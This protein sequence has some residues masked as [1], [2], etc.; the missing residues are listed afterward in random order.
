MQLAESVRYT[1]PDVSVVC[2]ELQFL[3]EKALTLLNPTLLVEVLLPSLD[4][5]DRGTKLAAYRRLASLQAYV[6]VPQRSKIIEVF[7]KNEAGQWTLYEPEGG[8]IELV[9]VEAKVRVDDVY[10]GVDS[11]SLPPS[12]HPS[13]VPE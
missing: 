2:G 7:R 9:S 5:Y 11:T 13:P 3:D 12:E 4:E 10:E 8:A 6:L 1:Y